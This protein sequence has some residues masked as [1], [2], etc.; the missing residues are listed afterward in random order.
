ME[1]KQKDDNAENLWRVHDTIYDLT[2]FI[3]KHPGGADWIKITKVIFEFKNPM[4]NF[5]H[6]Y[7]L[8]NAINITITFRELT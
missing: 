6:C 2:E 8:K 4:I 5:C 7:C 1:C 3:N